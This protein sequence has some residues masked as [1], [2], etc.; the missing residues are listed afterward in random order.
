MNSDETHSEGERFMRLFVAHEPALQRF[1]MSLAPAV[2]D[3]RDILQETAA[4]LWTK[5]AQYD[6]QRDF[7]PWACGI[8]KYKVREFWR[9]QQRWEVLA[10]GELLELI[11]SRREE[12]LPELDARREHLQTCLERLPQRQRDIMTGYYTEGRTVVD[13]AARERSS[14]EA[15][16]KLLQRVRRAL[17]ECVERGLQSEPG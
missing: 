17:L 16:Y 5:R 11:E 8:A 14:A 6:P 9:K 3:A 10:E 1:I 7:L 2:A 12:L 13:L 4:T 15:I